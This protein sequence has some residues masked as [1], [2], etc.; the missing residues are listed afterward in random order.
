MV[1]A[2]AARQ[3]ASVVQR[4]ALVAAVQSARA[5]VLEQVTAVSL[6]R[7]EAWLLVE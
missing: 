3:R 2:R 5:L 6:P 4:V 1:Q 7:P